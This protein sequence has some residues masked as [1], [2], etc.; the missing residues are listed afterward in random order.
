MGV[1]V[2]VG[3]WPVVG[4]ARRLMA[5]KTH[6][7]GQ[8]MQV[9]VLARSPYQRLRGCANVATHSARLDGAEGRLLDLLDLG[10]QFVELGIRITQDRHTG[11]VANIAVVISAGIDGQHIAGLPSLRGWRT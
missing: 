6:T 2:G 8:K 9:V 4:Q 3:Y 1:I 7:M 10:Q 11:D 5:D